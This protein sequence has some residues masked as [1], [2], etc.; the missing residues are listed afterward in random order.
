MEGLNQWQKSIVD[1]L[2]YALQHN[3]SALI[4]ADEVHIPM[5]AI[6]EITHLRA[7]IAQLE[8]ERDALRRLS[9]KRC[10]HVESVEGGIDY[11]S[12]NYSA[13]DECESIWRGTEETR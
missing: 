1:R 6:E 5:N 9:V 2:R 11:C 13:C 10:K 7:E 4:G 3:Q 12:L 8:W